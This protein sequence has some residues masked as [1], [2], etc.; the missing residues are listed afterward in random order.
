M[1]S[2]CQA[3][4]MVAAMDAVR[5]CTKG[6]LLHK[7]WEASMCEREGVLIIGVASCDIETIVRNTNPAGCE[8]GGVFQRGKEGL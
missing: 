7:V 3:A 4:K 8:E 2:P 1:V 6:G 5:A